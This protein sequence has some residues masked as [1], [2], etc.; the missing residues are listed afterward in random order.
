LTD[1]TVGLAEDEIV[2]TDAIAVVSQ[3]ALERRHRELRR[4]GMRRLQL[5]ER[6]HLLLKLDEE[7][8]GVA[9]RH[10]HTTP[11]D[12]QIARRAANVAASGPVGREPMT[13]AAADRVA[14]RGVPL[15]RPTADDQA[16]LVE[17]AVEERVV[18]G[19]VR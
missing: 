17:D 9:D 10:M 7:G 19:V 16:V 5:L 2:Q 15:G 4:G 6:A 8:V 11:R 1:D 18:F 3:V 12:E 14:K 13:L